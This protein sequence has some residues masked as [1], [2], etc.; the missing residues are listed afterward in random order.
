MKFAIPVAIL[1]A[2]LWLIATSRAQTAG[3]G[4]KAEKIKAS[5][6][7]PQDVYFGLRN[8]MLQ[9]SR[10]EF[11]LPPGTG[12]NDPWGVVMDWG[13]EKATV[14]VVAVSDGSASVYFS[15]G[16]GF[17]GGGGQEPIKAAAQRAVESARSVPLS[18][19]AAAPYPLP[20]RGGVVFYVLTDGGVYRTST[21]EQE[22]NSKGDSLRKLG[23]AMQGVITQYRLWS[24]K[25]KK[26]NRSD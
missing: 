24:E 6:T 25:Q 4:T 11:S 8:K 1:I 17:I 19:R 23:D 15:S 21:S 13:M 10:K 20:D 22:L 5:A 12:A 14:T 18:T 9:G 7:S 16:G 2:V 3:V 26:S